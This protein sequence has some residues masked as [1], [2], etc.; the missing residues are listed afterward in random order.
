MRRT[1]SRVAQPSDPDFCIIGHLFVVLEEGFWLLWGKGEGERS[2]QTC[3][4]L[5]RLC[6]VSL[7]NNRVL[8]RG[9]GRG[10]KDE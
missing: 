10:G 6:S 8:L 3:T 1:P 4:T 9:K 2:L 7:K 5:I